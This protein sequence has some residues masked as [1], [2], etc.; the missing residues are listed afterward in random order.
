MQR[1]Y[2]TN[3]RMIA[4]FLVAWFLPTREHVINTKQKR[5]FKITHSM[6]KATK[7]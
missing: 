2:V 4:W 6:V 5:N 1:G 7:I 3:E